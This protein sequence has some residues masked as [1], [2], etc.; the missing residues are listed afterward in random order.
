MMDDL[1][2]FAVQRSS[3]YFRFIVGHCQSQRADGGVDWSIAEG[4][5]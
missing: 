5:V 3:C 4:E 1:W 2:S